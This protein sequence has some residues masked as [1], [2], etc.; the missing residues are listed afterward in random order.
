MAKQDQQEL[1]PGHDALNWLQDQLYQQK[2]ASTRMQ[3]Q[4]E[5]LQ[6]MLLEL[7]EQAR[8][9]EDMVRD[10]NLRIQPLPHIQDETRRLEGLLHDVA[11]R[12]TQL[13]ARIEG[14]DRQRQEEAERSRAERTDAVRRIQELEREQESWLERQSALED[15][16]RRYQESAAKVALQIQSLSDTIESAEGKAGRAVESVNRLE[17]T[18]AEIENAV[19]ALR[20]EDEALAERLRLAHEIVHRLEST[21]LSRQDEVKQMPLLAERVELLRAERQ[22]LEDRTAKLEQALED[23][24]AR[25]NRDEQITSRQEGQLRGHDDQ[26]NGIREALVE[27]R[28]LIVDGFLKAAQTQERARRRQIEEMEREIKELKQHAAGLTT[29]D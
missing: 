2:A 26:I 15:A 8:R 1:L 25:L 13:A 4:V 27:Q 29:E 22:R 18:V 16:G 24:T 19:V 14:T 6:A 12:Q 5:Q 10:L 11:E 20:R 17:H 28:R 7:A 23:M 3:Q 21:V 9:T